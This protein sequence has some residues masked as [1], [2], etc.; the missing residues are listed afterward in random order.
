[1]S[2]GDGLIRSVYK[3]EYWRLI[4]VVNNRLGQFTN[5]STGD[6]LISIYK[7]E[8]WRLIRVVNNRLIRVVNNRLIRSVYKHEYWRRID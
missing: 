3:H 6:G 2:T 1:M 8:Y 4:R 5:M 7:H